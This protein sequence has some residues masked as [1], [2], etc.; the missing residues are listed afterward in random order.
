[1]YLDHFGLKEWPFGIT[2]DIDFTYR[3]P[4]HEDALTTLLMALSSGEGFVKVTGEVGTGKTLLCRTLLDRLA[5]DA[6]TAYIPNP[7]LSP[8]AMLQAVLGE[9]NLRWP[10]QRQRPLQDS[11][12]YAA[13]E[14]GLVKLA[15]EGRRVVLCIDEA[16]ALPLNTLEALRLL[17]NIETGKRK[18]LQVVLFG[19]PELDIRLDEPS[20]R[21]L[22]QRIT[23]SSNLGTLNAQDVEY[24]LAHR[25][26]IAGYRGAR[27][28]SRDAVRRLHRAS[29][30]VPR[31]VNILSHKALMAG[32]GEGARYVT[33][34][35]VKL[36]ILDTESARARS[37]A[38]RR[39]WLR[40]GALLTTLAAS[41]GAFVWTH[42]L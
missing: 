24:Y 16:Q 15:Q 23:F 13:V 14:S 7:Q 28:F 26:G 25:L 9:L 34:R 40:F 6:V 10:R 1:M 5:D 19:Q 31:L 11:E 36:A 30:G 2:P 35:Y 18:L 33:D 17:S 32:F 22:K 27:L 41:T 37:V 21:Q 42:W 29:R 20:I 38:V 3:A 12:L 4:A 8:T 39:R